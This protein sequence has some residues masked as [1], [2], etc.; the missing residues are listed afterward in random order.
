[1][2]HE[3]SWWILKCVLCCQCRPQISPQLH[4]SRPVLPG[5]GESSSRHA[6][7]T[8]AE[9]KR[10]GVGGGSVDI[11]AASKSQ[12]QAFTADTIT[13]H[14]HSF[15]SGE[16]KKLSEQTAAACTVQDV[17]GRTMSSKQPSSD[18]ADQDNI[19]LRSDQITLGTGR[20]KGWKM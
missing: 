17:R 19:N 16:I 13:Y 11:S 15:H 8:S 20:C 2:K 18:G 12:H 3:D 1:M 6:L 9:N 7:Y 4:H 10:R 14:T 5:N